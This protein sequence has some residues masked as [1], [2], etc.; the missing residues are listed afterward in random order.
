MK[1]LNGKDL[2]F[3]AMGSCIGAGIITN[4]GVAI[5]MAGSG[6]IIA[7]LLA[8]FVMFVTNLPTM[9][10]AT[11]HPAMS[12]QYVMTSWVSKKM[13]GFW[14]YCQIFAAFAQAYMGVAFG[15]YVNSIIPS[16]SVRA[17]AC[18]I[19]TL[20]FMLNLLDLKSSARV[21][22]VITAILL[23]VLVSFVLLGL[24]KCDLGRMFSKES[25][26]YGGTRG[27]F[28][29]CASVLFGVGGCTIL[30]NFGPQIDNPKRNIPRMTIITFIC[31]FLAFGLVSFVGSGVAPIAEIAGKPMTYQ[32]QIIYPGKAYLIFV[33]GGALLAIITTI[34][35]NYQRYW[36]S[37][38]RGVDEGWLPTFMG[39]RNKHGT[40][41]VLMVLFWLMALIPNLFNLNI[42]QLVSL[43]S[44]VTLIPMLIPIWG[45]LKLP[46]GDPEGW[47]ASKLSKYFA[48]PMLRVVFCSISTLIIGVFVVLNILQFTPIAAIFVV[49]YFAVALIICFGF[50]DKI[51][52]ARA[53]RGDMPHSNS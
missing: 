16:I 37:I 27:I 19:I 31:A 10:F 18:F 22:N 4:T 30:V 35:A 26:L 8:F 34:N 12:P 17:A 28:D 32:A 3:M 11:V 52:A 48:S 51:M 43:A 6:V 47:E 44:A 2:F 7:Y 9:F 21:Q 53:K 49:V 24:P 36:S 14:L 40:P 29:A 15:T 50:G 13:A 38:I 42:G 25:I 41:W 45:F 20:F 23:C 1:K 46:G 39:K 33:V 5:G